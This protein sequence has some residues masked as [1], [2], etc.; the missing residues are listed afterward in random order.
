MSTIRKLASGSALRAANLLATALVSM[1]I[2]PFVV[3]ALGDRMYG[4]WALVAATI[5]YY[6]TLQIGLTPAINRYMARAL[7]A[8]DHEECN[9]VFNTALRLLSAVGAVAL[10]VTGIL[11]FLAHWLAKNPSDAEVLWKLI[12]ILGVYAALLFP[13]RVLQGT[14]EAQLRYDRTAFIDLFSLGL[15]T[16]LL[17]VILLRGYKVVA[18]AAATVASGIP[19]IVLYVYFISKELPFL[20]LNGRY[21]S[22][23][24][25][26][27]L[28]SFGIYSF[29]A[30]IANIIRFRVDALVVAS[31][32]GLAAVT[33]YRIGSTLTQFF[34]GMMD[35]LAGFFP[36]VF[37]RQEGE[38]NFEGLKRTYFFAT[39]VT[40]C[41]ASF[42]GFALIAW[43]KPFIRVWMG[44][45]YLDA[46]PVL[47][48]LTAG[49][50]V[51]LAQTPSPQLLYGLAKHKYTALANSV[52]AIANLA[53]S[54]VLAKRYGMIGVALGTLIPMVLVKL[55]VQPVYVCRL[56][57]IPYGEYI[58]R[59]FKTVAA[60]AGALVIPLLLTLKFAAP[61]YKVLFPLGILSAILYVVPLWLFEFSQAETNMLTRAVWPRFA[62]KAARE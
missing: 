58:Q 40:I 49:L 39:K 50:I 13:S 20:R 16:V 38:G 23:E 17:I 34:S 8:K 43:G 59:F 47:V 7:G 56:A 51:A 5:G 32:V 48:V 4:A 55:F 46:Y 28:F 36:A 44:P 25:A 12:A 52:E 35:A 10:V 22:S 31:Y 37:S 2:M 19:A 26:R 27:K 41:I 6:G 15:R 61:S 30:N 54:I 42:V 14:L 21:W 60:V 18:L 3:H 53:L 29:V 62:V 33:H 9:R 1:F 57:N 24:T 45:A 11:A